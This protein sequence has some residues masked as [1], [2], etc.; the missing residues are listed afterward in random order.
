MPLESDIGGLI[1]EDDSIRPTEC[2]IKRNNQQTKCYCSKT[3]TGGKQIL[4]KENFSKNIKEKKYNLEDE[5]L[6]IN[7]PF[8]V[9]IFTSS[10]EGSLLW[11]Q[12][13]LSGY[14]C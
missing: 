10:P 13:P 8:L 6:S 12:L 7:N 5:P 1:F 11:L 2:K 14:S 4:E 9:F 3:T